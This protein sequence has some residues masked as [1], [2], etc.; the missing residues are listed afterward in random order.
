[1]VLAPVVE[2]PIAVRILGQNNMVSHGEFT[3]SM[4]RWIPGKSYTL[5]FKLSP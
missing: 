1:M 2:Y 5:L 3:S 4:R